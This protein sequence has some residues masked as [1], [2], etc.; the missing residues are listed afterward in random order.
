M[1]LGKTEGLLQVSGRGLVTYWYTM[2]KDRREYCMEELGLLKD[3]SK[4]Q[5]VP[6]GQVA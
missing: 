1:T 2:G 3:S 4:S 6:L 5:D